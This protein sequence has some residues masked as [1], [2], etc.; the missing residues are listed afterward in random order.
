VTSNGPIESSGVAAVSPDDSHRFAKLRPYLMPVSVVVGVVLVVGWTASNSRVRTSADVPHEVDD[1]VQRADA[2][3]EQRWRATKWKEEPLKPAEPA[4]DLQVLRRLSLAL[5]GTVPALEE[6]RQFEADDRPGKLRR[7]T[8]RMMDDKRFANYFGE[9]LARGFVGTEGGTFI[10]YRRDRFT[11]W[12][13]SKLRKN[14]PYDEIV[15]EMIASDGLWTG[16]PATNFM[17]AAYNDKKFDVNKLAG[18]SVRAFLGQRIDCAQCHDH[19]FNDHW[20]QHHFQGL[21]AFFGQS[22]VSPFGVEDRA[23]TRKGEPIEYVVEDRKTLKK[24]AVQPAVPFHPEWLPETGTRRERFAAW[25]THP[26]NRRFERATVNRVWALLF[27]RQYTY[28]VYP[29]DDLP[30]PD[31]PNELT[32]TKLLDILGSDFRR[33]NYDLRRL[34]LTMTSTKAFRMSSKHSADVAPESAEN[35]A[36]VARRMENLENNWA[37]FPLSRL[38]PEQVFGSMIQA[39][40]VRTID[41]NS[42]LFVRFVK[43]IRESDFIREYGDPGGDELVERAGTISQALVRMNG[44]LTRETGKATPFTAAGRIPSVSSTDEHC[45]ETAYLVIFCRRPTPRELEHWMTRLK[46]AGNGE[47]RASIVEDMYWAMFNQ[48]EFSW[49]H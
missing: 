45:V 7:W 23:T 43:A 47:S 36:D 44:K 40:S 48:T 28:P 13:R 46:E 4:S 26:E 11:S 34:I 22:Q 32:D 19:K 16:D 15:R 37:V 30:D 14:R 1:V 29:V 12:L 24:H 18:R 31:D 49:N 10:L 17:T 8:V 27:G 41:Q 20:K 3:L 9:R 38:R 6:I 21:A 35:E 39:A 33:H 2:H 42:N 25:I 5:H